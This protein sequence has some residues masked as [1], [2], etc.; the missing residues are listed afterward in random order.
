MPSGRQQSG[1][2]ER[3]ASVAGRAAWDVYEIQEGQGS[4][5]DEDECYDQEVAAD[6]EPYL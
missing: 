2:D 3:G 1:D 4:S 5:D 6:A